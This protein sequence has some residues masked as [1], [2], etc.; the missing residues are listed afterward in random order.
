M[1]GVQTCALP[2]FKFGDAELDGF[3]FFAAV[4]ARPEL[5]TLPFVFMSALR[6]GVIV[7]SGVQMGVDDYLVKPVDPD[8]LIAVIEGKL[9]RYR[10][11]DRS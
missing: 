10:Q 7:R 5:R 1:T 3:Q 9:K 6:D 11:F 4:Q 2:I 8:L